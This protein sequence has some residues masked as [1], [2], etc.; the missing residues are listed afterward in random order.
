MEIFRHWLTRFFFQR[1]YHR[2][3]NKGWTIVC[4]SPDLLNIAFP[5]RSVQYYISSF[6]RES[7][8][9]LRGNLP[10]PSKVNFFSITLYDTLGL[11]VSSLI[12][13]NIR[14]RFGRDEYRLKIGEDL[15]TSDDST[16][17][18][19]VRF[20]VND[21]LDQELHFEWLPDIIVDQNDCRDELDK[22]P[23]PVLLQRTERVN[24]EILRFLSRRALT[25]LSEH[26]FFV[27]SMKQMVSL[28]INNDARYMIAYPKRH[29]VIRIDGILPPNISSR[30]VLRFVGFMACNMR[31]TQ[32]DDSSHSLSNRYVV[33]VA[34]SVKSA[35]IFGYDPTHPSHHLL[36]WQKSN[37]TPIIVYRE[38]RTDRR[39]IFSISNETERISATECRRL[40]GK[41]YP[42]ITAW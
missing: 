12:D 4:K 35:C 38:V 1:L 3:I 36:L 28:F 11:P 17:C 30:H 10:P 8:V 22:V 7:R 19:I 13:S 6:I 42:V 2:Y 9:E 25:F 39:G 34:Y 32:T 40:M 20:Y 31:T 41:Y 16:Y 23:Y 27:P 5:D 37:T 14:S 33:W 24:Q 15:L 29:K 18:I 21:P 26:F